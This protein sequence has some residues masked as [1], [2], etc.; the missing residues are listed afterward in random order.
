MGKW[1]TG[2]PDYSFAVAEIQ[3]KIG[4]DNDLL[5]LYMVSKAKYMLEN[6]ANAKDAKL[7]KLNAM[8]LYRAEDQK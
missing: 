6:K 7:V 1:M 8:I 5:A 4:N 2:T 3:D